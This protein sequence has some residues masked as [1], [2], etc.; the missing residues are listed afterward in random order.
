MYQLA[1]ESD[2]LKKN[3]VV[4]ESDSQLKKMLERL[5]LRIKSR[6]ASLKKKKLA[7]L[8]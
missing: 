8:R 1:L 7:T 3:Q 4:A 6:K 5:K 2:D